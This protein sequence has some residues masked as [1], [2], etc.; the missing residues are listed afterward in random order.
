MSIRLS[1]EIVPISEVPAV[2]SVTNLGGHAPTQ[3]EDTKVSAGSSG[4]PEEEAVGYTV[5][6]L[7]RGQKA[8]IKQEHGK[9]QALVEGRGGST[10]LMGEYPS[11]EEALQ[12]LSD[13]LMPGLFL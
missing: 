2:E 4:T 12:A 1:F 8:W 5:R 10:E 3:T 11:M 7:P 9:Y 13:K 6:G